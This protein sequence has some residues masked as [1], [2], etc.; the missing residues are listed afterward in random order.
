MFD[1]LL[2]TKTIAPAPTGNAAGQHH[3]GGDFTHWIEIGF[4]HSR[5]TGTI[6]WFSWARLL[7]LLLLML[8]L[9]DYSP[10]GCHYLLV[11]LWMNHWW[12]CRYCRCHLP[13]CNRESVA[14]SN[15]LLQGLCWRKRICWDLMR[16]K[17]INPH[18]SCSS[19]E[20]CFVSQCPW[21]SPMIDIL[22]G[23]SLCSHWRYLQVSTLN[24]QLEI[25]FTHLHPSC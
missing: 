22:S 1:G 14:K 18:S 9:F 10:V 8:Q 7:L 4:G 23:P 24:K 11:R 13:V 15:W 20:S 3:T 6:H 5:W 21:H 2:P 17:T 16:Q 12:W 19:H 25:D